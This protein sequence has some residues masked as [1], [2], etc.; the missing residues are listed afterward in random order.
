MYHTVEIQW[1]LH[2]VRDEVRFKAIVVLI[3]QDHFSHN[4]TCVLVDFRLLFPGR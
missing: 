1:N 3:V 4:Y 2:R